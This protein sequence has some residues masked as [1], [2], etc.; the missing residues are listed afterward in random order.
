MLTFLGFVAGVI[1]YLAARR[2]RQAVQR[3]LAV[4]LPGLSERA[5]RRIAVRVFVHGAWSYVELLCISSVHPEQ[6]A[7]SFPGDGW[8]HVGAAT[9]AGRGIIMVTAHLGAPSLAGQLVVL[10]G[11]PTTVAVE[12]LNP[13]ALHD[14]VARYRG[15]LG[16]RSVPAGFR[17]ARE[18]VSTLRRNEVVGIV[19]DRDVAGSGE[20]LCFFGRPTRIPTAAAVLALRTG[21]AVLPAVAYRARPFAGVGHIE[22]PVEMPRTG[23]AAA[24]VREGTRRIIARM[25]SWIRAH[26]EQWVVFTDVWPDEGVGD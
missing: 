4:A 17:A 11:V 9:E 8:E 18:L 1:G 24:D 16:M 21:A 14:L 25:E 22:P 12:R 6:L 20:V 5:R 19:C 26:P 10:H 3:N 13:P 23:D 2:A 7:R 15:A